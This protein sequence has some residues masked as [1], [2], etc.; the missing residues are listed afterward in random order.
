MKVRFIGDI[1]NRLLTYLHLIKDTEFTIQVGDFST[2]YSHFNFPDPETNKI[3]FGN[4]ED[5]NERV[6]IPNFLDDFGYMKLGNHICFY[7]GGAYSID[8]HMTELTGDWSPKEE[9]SFGRLW[10]AYKFYQELQ[11]DI[12]ISH[13]SSMQAI[14]TLEL[15]NTLPGGTNAFVINSP[16]EQVLTKM[17]EWH[18]P[19]IHIFG[20]WHVNRD[21]VDPVTNTRMICLGIAN[22]VDI[23]L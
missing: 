22:Y 1:H 10:Q 11:P 5:H 3:L 16:T 12:L 21:R 23:E 9:L 20:H 14:E 4:H 2:N 15:L 18:K 19:K 8:R 13:T 7:L 6:K 17:V